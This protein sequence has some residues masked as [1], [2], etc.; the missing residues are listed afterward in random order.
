MLKRVILVFLLIVSLSFFLVSCKDSDEYNNPRDDGISDCN[1]DLKNG[2]VDD[3]VSDGFGNNE[4]ENDETENGESEEGES[5]DIGSGGGEGLED[6]TEEDG[7]D[8]RLTVNYV[9]SL[10]GEKYH[11]PTCYYA[12]SMK[13]ETKVEFSGPCDELSALGYS[14]CKVCKPDPNY[15]Y[16]QTGSNDESGENED[17]EFTYIL[18][19]DSKKF[20]LSGCSSAASMKEENKVYSNEERDELI[21]QGYLPCGKCKP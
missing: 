19:S 12:T 3:N 20:H 21:L 14:P 18:N 6:K 16:A 10:K 11:L 1:D 9:Y 5:D 7:D 8:S 17:S 2:T 13:P 4:N 15:D